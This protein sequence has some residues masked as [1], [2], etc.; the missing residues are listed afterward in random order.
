MYRRTYLEPLVLLGACSLA[1]PKVA[2]P[3]DRSIRASGTDAPVTIRAV[4]T[5]PAQIAAAL[6]SLKGTNPSE[7]TK[8]ATDLA[9]LEGA[10]PYVRHYSYSQRGRTDSLAGGVLDAFDV[11][12]AKRNVDRAPEWAKAGRYDLLVDVCL[13]LNTTDQ[14]KQ[15]GQAFFDFYERID[16]VPAEIRGQAFAPYLGYTMKTIDQKREV[17]HFHQKTGTVKTDWVG[18]G[19]V[20]AQSCE[21]TARVRFYWLVLTRER[22]KGADLPGDQWE[23]CCIFHNSDLELSDLMTSLV[24]CDGDVHAASN[25]CT[26]SLVI[27]SGSINRKD[28]ITGSNS[29]YVAGGNIVARS[30]VKHSNRFFAGGDIID[31]KTGKPRTGIE[32]EKPGLKENPFGVRFFQT[33]DVGVELAVEYGVVTVAKLTPGSPL[34]KYGVQVGD[35][36]TQV[37]DKPTL[38]LNDA[39]RELRYS[40]ALE[41][42][43]VHIKRGQEKLTRVV[44]FK[45]GLEK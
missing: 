9:R 5:P 35:V 19:L 24:V 33:A 16:S 7:R 25:F 43:I 23:N 30:N 31:V 17:R 20:R 37:N 21:A 1:L 14:L 27:A 13:H 42:G 26:S 11:E 8:A 12:R 18:H 3:D 2:I 22:L 32:N 40:V 10:E 6:N 44:Y 34:T 29:V 39:R 41:A 15:V 4:D 45:N 28:G 36:I 38:T